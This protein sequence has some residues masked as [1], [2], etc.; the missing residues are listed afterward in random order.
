[1]K[2]YGQGGKPIKVDIMALAR[3]VTCENPTTTRSMIYYYS[4]KLVKAVASLKKVIL[5]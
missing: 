4:L 5:V 2:R 1:M 3:E